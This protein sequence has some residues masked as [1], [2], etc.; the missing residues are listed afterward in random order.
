MLER[1]QL[2]C[3]GRVEDRLEVI[4][5]FDVV[6]GQDRKTEDVLGMAV[7]RL[8]RRLDLHGR[9]VVFMPLIGLPLLHLADAR[10]NA[11]RPSPAKSPFAK[12]QV[13]C[14]ADEGRAGDHRQ[15]CQ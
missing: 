14:S 2:S 10:G 5:Q 15:P 8:R 11:R 13:R 9:C 4:E 7:D 6:A 3:E 1:P 12:K